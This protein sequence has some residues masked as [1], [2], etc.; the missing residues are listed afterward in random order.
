[1]SLSWSPCIS[2][3]VPKKCLKR[4]SKK[5]PQRGREIVQKSRS[6]IHSTLF[7]CPESGDSGKSGE[8]GGIIDSG[9]SGV[10]GESGYSADSDESGGSSE[11]GDSGESVESG[12]SVEL[13]YSSD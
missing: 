4:V 8:T 9:D 5:W 3:S 10:S 13:G 2:K 7:S 12:D 11:S 1:M 6:V